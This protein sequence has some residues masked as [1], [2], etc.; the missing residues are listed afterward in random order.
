MHSQG[1]GRPQF[2]IYCGGC[3][4]TTSTLVG[5]PLNDLFLA[6]VPDLDE[7]TLASARAGYRDHYALHCTRRSTLY[8]GITEA[9]TRLGE[10]TR[11]GCATTK[12]PH[13]AQPVI[14]GFGLTRWLDAWRGTDKSLRYKP[15]PDLLLAIAGDLGVEPGGMIYVGDSHVDIQAA[16]AAGSLAAWLGFTLPSAAIMTLLGLGGNGHLG[17]NEPGTPAESAEA[18]NAL[19]PNQLFAL[20]LGAVT[21]HTV[22]EKV[23][24]SCQELIVPGAIRSLA[25][26]PVAHPIAVV[27]QGNIITD[28]HRPYWGKYTGDEDTRRKPAYHNGTAWTWV[29]P[30]FCEA[31]ADCFGP[32]EFD[33]A[34]AWL[35]S[36]TVLINEGCVGHVPEIVDGDAPHHQRGCDAQAWGASELLRVWI[37][38]TSEDN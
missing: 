4:A 23:L 28:P 26:R 8:P 32:E 31:W 19:R 15:A 21:N 14:E 25:D 11:L 17:L 2:P 24:L 34:L 33:T 29:F 27:H 37:K 9:L 36:S 22:A 38:L 18:D 1:W 3:K 12:R 30:S 13:S 6:A 5:R 10:R 7:T 20:T 35:S 16:H